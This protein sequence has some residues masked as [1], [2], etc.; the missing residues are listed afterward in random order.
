VLKNQIFKYSRPIFEVMVD[1]DSGDLMG[2]KL[3]F[4][5]DKKKESAS[6]KKPASNPRKPKPSTAHTRKIIHK[7]D[8]G[9]TIRL[10]KPGKFFYER[11]IYIIV[12]I[13][14]LVLLF[15]GPMDFS[16]GF[17]GGNDSGDDPVDVAAPNA[18]DNASVN[19]TADAN[20]SNDTSG[21]TGS[22]DTGGLEFWAIKLNKCEEVDVSYDGQS[23]SSKSKCEEALGGGNSIT[24]TSTS[25]PKTCV[26]GD[27]EIEIRDIDVDSD[28][29]KK[30]DSVVVRITNNA[31]KE[32]DDF[33]LVLYWYNSGTDSDVKYRSKL[34]KSFSSSVA[35]KYPFIGQNID[36]CGGKKD[37][38]LDSEILS[39]FVETRSK[40]NTFEVRMYEYEDDDEKIDSATKV[41]KEDD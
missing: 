13:V 2:D 16:F 36:Q 27:I 1:E 9:L 19:N 11:L 18:T 20:T 10:K 8:E 25:T 14:L 5:E 31:N 17:G 22:I 3:L 21:S 4:E 32:L 23:Y 37:I 6:E 41:L 24:G 33:H 38:K 15:R 7:D 29:N 30:I 28:N 40:D 26:D 12:I 35:G 39:R 34:R